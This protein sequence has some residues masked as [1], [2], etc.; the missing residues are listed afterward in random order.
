MP[1]RYGLPAGPH[2]L[3]AHEEAAD[4]RPPLWPVHVVWS[5]KDG[6]RCQPADRPSVRIDG[7]EE[8]IIRRIDPCTVEIAVAKEGRYKLTVEL[9]SGGRTFTGTRSILV[10]D[11]L[12]FGL[13]DSN[14]SGEGAP[15]LAG[16]DVVW[17]SAQC[18]RSS[19]SY[20]A[21]AIAE[22]ERD[23][24]TSVTFVHLACSGA[25]IVDGLLGPYVG[26]EPKLGKPL[27]S[28]VAMLREL[29]GTREI[30]AVV[31]SIGVNDLR[32]GGLVLHCLTHPKCPNEPFDPE[33]NAPR[34]M[35]KQWMGKRLRELPLRFAD[36]AAALKRAGV[37]KERVYLTEYF[38][39][40]RDD[41]E[42]TC[43]PLIEFAGS[44]D[45]FTRAEAQW[46]YAS[47]LVPL[48]EEVEKAAKQWA[49]T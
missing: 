2:R 37:R 43:D 3:K 14:G 29:A 7:V 4:V 47:V 46:A 15:N 18:H 30:D 1:P 20:Q 33:G 39:S 8:Q 27:E 12:V 11:W 13:G 9:L 23:P 6:R 41:D 48:N 35:L 38:D 42:K 40:T 10:Q 21:L 5:R 19:N 16:P 26:I 32:F 24:R 45:L 22:L 31:I 44:V 25:S 17:Q 49:G 28:Q 36:L 34:L